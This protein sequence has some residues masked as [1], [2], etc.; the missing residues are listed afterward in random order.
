MP[1]H[2]SP[3]DANGEQTV[4]QLEELVANAE[5]RLRLYRDELRK[6]LTREMIKGTRYSPAD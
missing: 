1:M 2:E 4:E 5:H 3:S 6:Q